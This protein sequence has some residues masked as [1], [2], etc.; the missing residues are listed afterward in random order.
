VPVNTAM[1]AVPPP[2]ILT[3]IT[4]SGFMVTFN[5]SAAPLPQGVY[6]F[7]HPTLGTFQMLIVPGGRG[8]N[9]Y[10]AVFNSLTSVPAAHLRPP[11]RFRT[12]AGSGSSGGVKTPGGSGGANSSSPSPSPSFRE[13]AQQEMEPVFGDRVKPQLPE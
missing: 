8:A 1:M 11:Q 3:P 7:Q 9:T 4:T 13:P 5:T 10:T 6:T 12:D 2:R